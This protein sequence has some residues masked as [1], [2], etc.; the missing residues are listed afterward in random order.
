MIYKIISFQDQMEDAIK[1]SRVVYGILKLVNDKN[2]SQKKIEQIRKTKQG[3][4]S[5]VL[6]F[7]NDKIQIIQNIHER[8]E[9][10]EHA[11]WF[12]IC[13]QR[14]IFQNSEFKATDERWKQRLSKAKTESGSHCVFISQNFHAGKFQSQE[15]QHM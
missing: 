2:E 7:H 14:E 13:K 5:S 9:K 1:E 15:H 12:L 4:T 10:Y 6:Q 3:S 8:D 11:L